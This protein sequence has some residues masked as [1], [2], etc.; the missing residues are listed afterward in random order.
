MCE[1][2]CV[3]RAKVGAIMMGFMHLVILDGNYSV[4]TPCGSVQSSAQQYRSCGNRKRNDNK[5]IYII[6]QY[7]PVICVSAFS[8][9]LV[10][11]LA[12]HTYPSCR[13]NQYK[14]RSLIPATCVPAT[15]VSCGIT[16]K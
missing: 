10:V 4:R 8:D 9:T 16:I 6:N 14:I 11:L 2:E 5:T 7:A 13:V 12:A 3:P 1:G 15:C